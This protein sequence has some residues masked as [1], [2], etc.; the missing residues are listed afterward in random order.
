M[1]CISCHLIS[2]VT[3]RTIMAVLLNRPFCLPKVPERSKG[4]GEE[5][6]KGREHGCIPRCLYGIIFVRAEISTST[7]NCF[8]YSPL[9]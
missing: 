7:V 8:S 3:E 2:K 4:R 5:G 1:G 9:I 6:C